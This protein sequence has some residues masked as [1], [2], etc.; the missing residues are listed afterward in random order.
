MSTMGYLRRQDFYYFY[1]CLTYPNRHPEILGRL[2]E[3]LSKVDSTAVPSSNKP[4][5]PRGDPRLWGRV[6]TNFGDYDKLKFN[7]DNVL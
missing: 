4:V 5:D 3:E 6:Y 2:L 7:S 1:N